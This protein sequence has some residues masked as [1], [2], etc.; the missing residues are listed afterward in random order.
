VS[1]LMRK[2]ASEISFLKDKVGSPRQHQK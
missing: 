2:Y 1:I